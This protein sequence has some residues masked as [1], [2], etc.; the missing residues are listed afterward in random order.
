LDV[1]SGGWD[2]V[3]TFREATFIFYSEAFFA[4]GVLRFLYSR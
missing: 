1:P 3:V 4:L 2:L